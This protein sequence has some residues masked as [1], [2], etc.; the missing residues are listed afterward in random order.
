MCFP[1]V[2]IWQRHTLAKLFRDFT[3]RPGIKLNMSSSN[4]PQNDGQSERSI[5]TLNRLLRTYTNS[6]HAL[7]DVLLPQIEYVYYSTPSQSSILTPF[8]VDCGYIPMEPTISTDAEIRPRSFEA[9]ALT[10]HLKTITTIAKDALATAQRRQ[11]TNHD[12]GR[13]EMGLK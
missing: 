8:E 4:H 3:G 10:R 13:K 7:W 12:K 9:V 6:D 1:I 2:H 11:E 5:Q